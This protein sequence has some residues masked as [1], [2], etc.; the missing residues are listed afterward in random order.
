M[1]PKLTASQFRQLAEQAFQ[2][3][4]GNQQRTLTL[5]EIEESNSNAAG[6]ENIS[7]IFHDQDQEAPTLEQGMFR[8]HHDAI[9]EAEL[10]AVPIQHGVYQVIIS[11]KLDP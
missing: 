4:A 1:N 10:F 8:F 7:L 5:K 2:V 11:Q 3:A 6:F 9:G